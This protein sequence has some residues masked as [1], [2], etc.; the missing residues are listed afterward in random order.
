M[1]PVVRK[2]CLDSD[3]IIE[4]LNNTS[5]RDVLAAFDANFYCTAITAY[6]VWFGRKKSESVFPFLNSLYPLD[7]NSMTACFAADIHRTLKERGQMIDSRDMFIGAICIK[8]NVEL[9]T[10]NKKHFERLKEFGLKLA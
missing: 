2:I 10:F 6:E 8:N 9:F 5:M 7:F 4:L 1:E 3:V